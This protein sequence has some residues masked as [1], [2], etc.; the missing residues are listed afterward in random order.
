MFWETQKAKKQVYHQSTRYHWKRKTYR[1]QNSN[2]PPNDGPEISAELLLLNWWL[3]GVVARMSDLRLAVVGL[4]PGHGIA[5]FSKL[6]D[7][8]FQVNYLGM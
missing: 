8:F 2:N 1:K 6:G 7:R 4:N 5:G 3:R